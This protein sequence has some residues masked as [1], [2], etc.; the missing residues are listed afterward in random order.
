M[1]IPKEMNCYCKKKGEQVQG[2]QKPQR[3]PPQGSSE[4]VSSH[5]SCSSS[6]PEG[7]GCQGDL[8]RHP[9]QPPEH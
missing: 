3:R 1:L 7:P 2:G 6:S 5:P 8:L 9:T 4:M